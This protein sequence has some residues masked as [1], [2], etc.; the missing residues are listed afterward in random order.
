MQ[1]P[2]E[3]NKPTSLE[4][5]HFDASSKRE[6]HT[7]RTTQKSWLN[8]QAWESASSRGRFTQVNYGRRENKGWRQEKPSHQEAIENSS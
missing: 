6:A 7:T 3:M 2:W 5:L 4:D 8:T 1:I